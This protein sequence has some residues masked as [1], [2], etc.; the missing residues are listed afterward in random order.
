MKLAAAAASVLLLF[1]PS[2]C[3]EEDPDATSGFSPECALPTPEPGIEPGV[4]P[5]PFLLEGVELVR[6]H[7]TRNRVTVALNNPRTVQA[8]FE[9]FRRAATKAGF[10]IVGEDNEGF[11]AEIYLQRGRRYGSIQIRMSRC[12]EATVAFINIVRT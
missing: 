12:A 7:E 11:E 3:S 4:V 2:G 8:S 5:G 10:E 1:A 9:A 6:A